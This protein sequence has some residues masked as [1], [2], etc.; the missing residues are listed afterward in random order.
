[1]K[2]LVV[3]MSSMGDVICTLPSLTEASKN[4]KNLSID[5]VVE[6]GFAEIPKWHPAVNSVITI[7]LRRWRYCLFSKSTFKEFIK[8]YQTLKTT[9]YDLVIDPQGLLKSALVTAVANGTSYGFDKHSIR[10]YLAAYF[11]RK[12]IKVPLNLHT[13]ER[14][15]RLFA[16][17]LGYQYTNTVPDYGIAGFAPEAKKDYLVLVHGSSKPAKCWPITKWQ[18]LVWLINKNNLAIKLTWGNQ[19]ELANANL[20]ANLSNNIEIADTPTLNDAAKL[21]AKAKAVVTVDTGFSHLATAL[22]TP[23]LTLYG[24][25]NPLLGGTYGT[26]QIQLTNMEQLTPAEVWKTLEKTLNS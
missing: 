1:M 12:K 17:S 7:A 13:V 24:V 19:I 3:K 20:I 8:F 4:I 14:M 5:W 2:V 9:K 22:S 26:N 10:E 25:T 6:E 23:T 18:E 16:A 15:R 21:I 11:Y